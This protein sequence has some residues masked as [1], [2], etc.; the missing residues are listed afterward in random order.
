MININYK[1]W[2]FFKLQADRIRRRKPNK[3]N[4]NR[5][6]LDINDGN[7][8]LIELISSGKPF[9][10]GK[11]GES[12]LEILRNHFAILRSDKKNKIS[13]FFDYLKYGDKYF[14]T[15]LTTIVKDSGY[16]P[17]EINGL[18][19]FSEIYIESIK[20]LDLLGSTYGLDGWFNSKGEDYVLDFVKHNPELISINTLDPYLFLESSWTQ[21]L[22]NKKVLIIHPFEKSIK[23]GFENRNLHFPTPLLPSFELITYKAVQSV[24]F[25]N[26]AFLNWFEALEYM[27]KDILK[28]DFDIALIG[29]G[30][31]GFPLA[32][33]V[34]NMGKQALH[35]GGAL[36]LYFGIIGNRWLSNPQVTKFVNEG[37]IKPDISEIP[38]KHNIIGDGNSAYW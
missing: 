27:K 2:D 15:G 20:N 9:M 33:L 22:A 19:N 10:V 28:I 14:W 4:F 18:Q 11:F 29:C 5:L 30:A 34:K 7:K 38:V 16:F 25:E 35:I 36:Q 13:L 17:S 26:T 3:R 32:S 23:T 1:Y 21:Y 8:R 12:E 31:Y 6:I 37:W 24:A